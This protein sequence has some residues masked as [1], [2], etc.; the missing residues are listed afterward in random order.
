MKLNKRCE[1]LFWGTS[2]V[3]TLDFKPGKT[4][5]KQIWEFV[6]LV[7]WFKTLNTY[8]R[9]LNENVIYEEGRADRICCSL[10]LTVPHVFHPGIK[11]LVPNQM[12]TKAAQLRV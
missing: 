6:V 12:I 1:Y 11:Q 5:D 8:L 10:S 4:S 3:D 2:L 9:P 7:I